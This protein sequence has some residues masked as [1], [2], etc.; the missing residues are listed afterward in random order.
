MGFSALGA[1]FMF[2]EWGVKV[3]SIVLTDGFKIGDSPGLISLFQMALT[4][5]LTMSDAELQIN[6]FEMALTDGFKLSDSTV[7][8]IIRIIRMF[9][10][11]SSKVKMDLKIGS[12]VRMN[13]RIKGGGDYHV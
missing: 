10:K 9:L 12:K 11:V 6:I 3:E 1:D 4:D 8:R 5:G 2:E 7:A 13:L